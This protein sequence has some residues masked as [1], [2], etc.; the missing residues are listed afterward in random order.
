MPFPIHREKRATRENI[1]SVIRI[2][3]APFFGRHFLSTFFVAIFWRARTFVFF[4]GLF[5]HVKERQR[6]FYGRGKREDTAD[7]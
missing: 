4:F 7:Q 2:I 3:Y 1:P 6:R 5:I